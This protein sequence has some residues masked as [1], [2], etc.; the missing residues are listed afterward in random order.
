MPSPE[1][2]DPR[3]VS[4]KITLCHVVAALAIV[5]VVMV[6]M[7]LTVENIKSES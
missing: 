7:V 4:N 2:A 5:L 1:N 3:A 6:M